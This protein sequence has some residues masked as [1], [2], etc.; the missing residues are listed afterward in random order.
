MVYEAILNE[1]INYFKLIESLIEILV[2]KLKFLLKNGFLFLQ[3][4]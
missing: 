4:G 1:Q 3:K 2:N